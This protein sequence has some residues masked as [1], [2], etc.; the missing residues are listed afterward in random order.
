[1]HA[2]YIVE[3]NDYLKEGLKYDLRQKW[4]EMLGEDLRKILEARD[5]ENYPLWFKLLRNLHMDSEYKY[6]KVDHDDYEK[7]LKACLDAIKENEHAYTSHQAG[8]EARGKL[9]DKLAELHKF[10]IEMLDKHKF[11]GSPEEA[12]A[13]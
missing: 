2:L 6:K 8:T 11:F 4:A 5:E 1:M 13:W 10:L 9:H 3:V 7:K 12:E